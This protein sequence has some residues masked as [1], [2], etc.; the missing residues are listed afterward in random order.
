MENC[1]IFHGLA[2]WPG[3][4]GLETFYC[5]RPLNMLE[6]GCWIGVSPVGMR[7]RKEPFVFYGNSIIPPRKSLF[8]MISKGI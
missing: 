6:Y 4:A 8:L 2:R 5:I 1:F 7:F 3:F